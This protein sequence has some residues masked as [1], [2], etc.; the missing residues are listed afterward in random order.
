MNHSPTGRRPS[1]NLYVTV[2]G[3]WLLSIAWFH[4]RL[5]SLMDFVDTGFGIA[6]VAFFVAFTYVAWLYAFY[7]VA[8]IAYALIYRHYYRQPY[9]REAP[10]P[11]D[12]PTVAILYTTCN[13]FEEASVRSCLAQDYPNFKLYLLDDSSDPEIKQRID[14]FALTDPLR[15]Q[16]VRRTDRKGFK[17]GN[18]NHG[19][20]SAATQEPFFALV[21]ADEVLPV[22]FLSRLMPRILA[23]ERCGFVQAIH[24]G[25]PSDAS[26]LASALGVGIDVHWRWYHPLRNRFGFVMLLGHGALLRRRP[27]EEV[28]GFPNLVSEDLAYALRIRENGWHGLFADD[29]V[30]FENFPPDM[31]AFR[32]R[33]MKWT[34]GTCEFLYR[35]MRYLLGSPRIPLVEKLDILFPTLGLPLSLFFFVF[36]L[37][38]NVALPALF[39]R[40]QMLTIAI[41]AREYA[42]PITVLDGR[43]GALTGYDFYAITLIALIA[44]V[45]AFIIELWRMP[46]RLLAFL[47]HS[48]AVYGALGPLSCIGVVCFSITRQAVFHVTA[49]R[50]RGSAAATLASGLAPLENL[51]PAIRRFLVRSH[52]DHALVQSIEA[53]LGVFFVLVAMKSF[54]VSFLG[55]ALAYLLHP[56]LHH[57]PWDGRFVRTAVHVPAALMIGGLVLG[58]L[59]LIGIQP[60]FLNF[61]VHF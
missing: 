42:L 28:G 48:V 10:L 9:L 37:D 38:V 53:A 58:S 61:G 20:A 43:F 18:I 44:P 14:L 3:L 60:V 39:G 31:R 33:H 40:E 59:S 47:S 5:W 11:A 12:P 52:P 24:R 36:V 51:F 16:V 30:C 7:N 54:Q 49:D 2:F 32:V 4:G 34:R 25:N 6:A 45:L 19:L 26:P 13:D 55:L 46:G 1:P 22:D 56:L 27:W 57:L 8:V 23:D 50:S 41:G 29:V 17:A 15:I 21:D 35:K